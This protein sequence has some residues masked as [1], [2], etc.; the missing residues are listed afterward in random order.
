MLTPSDFRVMNDTQM[1]TEFQSFCGVIENVLMILDSRL[2]FE[3]NDSLV[4]DLKTG[5]SFKI[6][7]V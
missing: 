2:F 4:I 7:K 3:K 5:S 1:N 6:E